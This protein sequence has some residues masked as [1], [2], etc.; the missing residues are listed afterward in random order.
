MSR[1]ALCKDA[2]RLTGFG[3][4]KPVLRFT[5]SP[6]I[7]TCGKSSKMATL[8]KVTAIK[9]AKDLATLPLDELIGNLKVYEMILENDGVASK[10]SKGKVKSLALKSKVIREKTSDDSD[11]QGKGDK[12]EAEEFNLMAKNF[13]SGGNRFKKGRGNGFRIRGARNSRQKHEFYNCGEEGH[14][15]GKCL[16]HKENKVF[17]KGTW[18]DSKD[19]N[20]P[21]KGTTCL[22][23]ID[24]Q[25][26]HPNT[27]T[28][29]NNVDL[30]ELQKEN[31]KLV[32]FENDFA[33]TFE[34]LLKE[35]HSLESEQ[36][37]LLNKINDL[38]FKVKKVTNDKEVV[39]PCQKCDVLTQ[40]V[41]SLKCNVSKLQDEALNFLKFKKNSIVLE[42]IS[43]D[44]IVDSGCTKH[45]TRNRRLF[46]SYKAY[47][48]GHVVFRSNLKGKVIGGGNITHD[49]IT[50]S[51]VEHVSGLAFN[52]TSV[53]DD[54]IN[55]PIVQDGNGSPSIQVNVSDEGYPK[56]VKEARGHPIEQV[57]NE[58]NERT[59]R[60]KTKQA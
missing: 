11:S 59:L 15:I 50:I 1:G 28:S 41:D 10:T 38:E 4:G 14:F 56:S 53:E 43:D 7:L 24:S 25:E 52:L 22:M 40:E 58:L 23:A 46:T 19:G 34:K 37:K 36:S 45:M 12:D 20:E 39:E 9:E 29:N 32:K 16:K 6:K 44:W 60:S 51:N 57:I 21:Q 8:A 17:V 48:G 2:L 55:E 35:K 30:H 27:S 42:N 54:R 26:V 33:K 49:S 18:S 3:F 5:L 13:R 31:E 47:D